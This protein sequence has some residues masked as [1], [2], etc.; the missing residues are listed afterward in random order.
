ML[1]SSY[2]V[3][4]FGQW[5]PVCNK[6]GEEYL[7]AYHD[8]VQ[9]SQPVED[10]RGRLDLYKLYVQLVYRLNRKHGTLTRFPFKPF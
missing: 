6:F 3:D 10:Y 1:T 8:I 9:I 5:M 2:F 7:Q 4:E